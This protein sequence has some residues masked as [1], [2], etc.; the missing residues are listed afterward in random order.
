MLNSERFNKAFG[1]FDAVTHSYAISAT[2]QALLYGILLAGV[3]VGCIISAPIGS[4]Y[5]RRVGLAL[6]AIASIVG[7]IIQLS[8]TIIGVAI[9]GRFIS[10]L[11][12]G[13]AANFCIMYWAE[14][15]P[16]RYRGM[17]V[18]MYQGFINLSQFVGACVNQGTHALTST[19]AWRGPL[20]IM[21]GAPT[22]LLIAVPF[23]PDTPST[24]RRDPFI[25]VK[26]LTKSQDG[27]SKKGVPMPHTN[28][29]AK[30]AAPPG[31]R[32]PL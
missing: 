19:W 29:C 23:L 20:I 25:D 5:G 26:L 22:V 28:L 9:A 1:T 3:V 13:F 6:C 32:I 12:I 15:T 18:M 21:L 31:Q 27:S 17:I 10:G 4:R 11:G 24:K 30:F 7:P 16:A 8:S 2:D 14:T